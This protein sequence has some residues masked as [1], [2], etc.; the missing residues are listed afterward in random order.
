MSIE[1]VK[2]YK[3]KE[4]VICNKSDVSVWNKAGYLTSLQQKKAAEDAKVIKA[5]EDDT[6]KDKV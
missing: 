6:K 2:V 1:T 3:G 5:A 4:S